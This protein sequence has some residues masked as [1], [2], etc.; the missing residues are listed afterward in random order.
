MHL[1]AQAGPKRTFLAAGYEALW[2]RYKAKPPHKRH[3][4]EA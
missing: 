3:Y 4:Y 1:W 2:L